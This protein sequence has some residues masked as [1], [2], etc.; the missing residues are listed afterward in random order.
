MKCWTGVLL[1]ACVLIAPIARAADTIIVGTVGAASANL[2]PVYIGMTQKLFEKE[3][4]KIDLVFAQSSAAVLQQLTA[5]SMNVAISVGLVDPIRAIEKGAPVA[6][7]RL[8]LQAPPYAL[9]GRQG[10]KSLRD[11]KGRKIIVGGVKDITRVFVERMLAPNG[12]QSGEVDWIF[13]GS[14]SARFAALQS[15]AVDAAILLPPFNFRAESAGF[16]NLGFVIEYVKD[17]PFAGT[18]VHT[19]WANASRQAVQRF[20]SAYTKSIA[21]FYDEGNRKEAI[22]LMVRVSNANREDTE[23]TYDFLFKGRYFEPTGKVSRA[24]LRST[25]QA[26]H[27]LGDLEQPLQAERLVLPGVAEIV[28]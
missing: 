27:E 14:T 17:I 5:G 25:V 19:A 22:D 2:W 3:D 12:V 15:G 10:L 26:L 8:E 20:L 23:K 9:L 13:A 1:A 16:V 28:D 4:L 21:W 24:K 7:V 18:V 11:L 6:I